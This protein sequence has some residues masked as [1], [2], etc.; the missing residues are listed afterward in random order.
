M[1]PSIVLIIG[2]SYAGI[3]VANGILKAVPSGKV[4]IVMINPSDKWYFNIAGPRIFAKPRAFKPDQYLLSIPKGLSK[5]SK[6]SFEFVQG[7]VT[8]I[9]EA[10][11][12][13]S[14]IST[15]GGS[16]TTLPYDHLVIASGSSTSSATQGAF[17]PFK[18]TG[19]ADLE[20]AIRGGQQTISEAKS[21]IIGG[22]GPIGVELAGE[23][24]EDRAGRTGTSITLVSATPRV[25]PMLKKSTSHTAEKLLAKKGVKVIKGHMVTTAQKASHNNQWTVTL[26]DGQNLTADAYISSTGVVPN[27]GFIPAAFLDDDGWVIVDE[28]LRVKNAQ[29]KNIYALGDITALPTR[30][31]IKVGERLPVLLANLKAD[32]LADK[33]SKRSTYS[34]DA[35]KEKKKIMMLVPVGATAGTGQMMGM[36]VWGFMV[37]FMKGKDFFVSRAAGMVGL[38]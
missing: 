25:L 2:G 8:S 15:V 6:S 10:S 1:A 17:V 22:A 14:V 34:T 33:S 37:N 9:D 3:Q 32:V 13:V 28:E 20:A 38:A 21:I 26:A 12:T 29:Q 11:H 36:T 31:A 16:P 7:T 24:A 30:T 18:P 27:N 35:E 23:L 5:H 4:K 19:S